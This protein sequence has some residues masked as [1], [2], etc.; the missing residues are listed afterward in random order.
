MTVINPQISVIIPV[1]NGAVFLAETLESII[2]QDWC[3]L[4]ILV[5]DDGSTDY[6][7]AV[8]AKFSRQVRYV[9]QANQG[10]ASARNYGIQ[11]AQGGVL[12]F[13]DADDLWMPDKLARQ[14]QMMQAEP[15][16]EAVLGGVKNF[17]SPELDE[18]QRQILAKSAA[19]TGNLHI[20]SMLIRRDAFLRV[21][22][23]NTRW[24]HG[25]FIDWWA[26]AMRVNL[27]YK[28]LPEV[29]LLRRLH[30]S[31]MTRREKDGRKEYLPMLRELLAQRRATATQTK[32]SDT[33]EI[34]AKHH[35]DRASPCSIPERAECQGGIS[36]L[37]VRHRPEPPAAQPI[38]TVAH[39]LSQS[40]SD[41]H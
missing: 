8:A 5:I 32:N 34:Y 28:I 22:L 16:C 12:T 4:E 23:F 14:M 6:T 30:T 3:P 20:G 41:G 38:C 29:V 35:T 37:A 17:I 13:L 2:Q 27:I 31:N 1:F 40:G 36:D 26:R 25:E 11:L 19:Q 9:H 15:T 39:A 7:A 18:R 33:E 10:A 24:R 21:G